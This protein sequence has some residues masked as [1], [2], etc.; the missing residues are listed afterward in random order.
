M[1]GC[2]EVHRGDFDAAGSALAFRARTGAPAPA[3]KRAPDE[4]TRRGDQQRRDLEQPRPGSPVP[5]SRQA[6]SADLDEMPTQPRE[7]SEV[8]SEKQMP[9]AD[10]PQ[11]SSQGQG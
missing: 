4:R 8:R 3:R 2:H 9:P 10:H 11:G 1:G 6:H 7:A 5:D